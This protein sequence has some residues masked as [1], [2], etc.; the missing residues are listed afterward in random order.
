MRVKLIDPTVKL[1]RWQIVGKFNYLC[2]QCWLGTF[3]FLPLVMGYFERD[4]GN[5]VY[6]KAT[7]W[8]EELTPDLEPS[9]PD[10]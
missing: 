6:G 2:A 1:S 9:S 7:Q 4:S 10:M 8:F 3:T 5:T